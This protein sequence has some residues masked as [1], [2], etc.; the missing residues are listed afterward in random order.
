M[1]EEKDEFNTCPC[2]PPEVVARWGSMTPEERLPYASKHMSHVMD[3]VLA[4]NPILKH[5]MKRA[6]DG[7]G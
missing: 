3:E 5:F 1:E 4:P 7:Q 6:K 2:I